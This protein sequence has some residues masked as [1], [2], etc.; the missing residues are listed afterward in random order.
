MIITWYVNGT[1]STNND[2]IQLGVIAKGAELTNS[3]LE[4]IGYPHSNIILQY[5]INYYYY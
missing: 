5:Y 4:I 2:P 1:G 3:S